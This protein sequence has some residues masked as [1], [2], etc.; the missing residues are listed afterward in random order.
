MFYNGFFLSTAFTVIGV[1]I[2]ISKIA[3]IQATR[4]RLLIGAIFLLLGAAAAAIA[5]V[6][7]SKIRKL[8]V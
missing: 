8:K 2:L 6:A 1:G 7:K 3:S 4:D 5:W